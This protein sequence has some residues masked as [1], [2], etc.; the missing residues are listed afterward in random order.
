MKKLL[1]CKKG[2]KN[3]MGILITILFIFILTAAFL[4]IIQ[5]EFGDDDFVSNDV[6]GLITGIPDNVCA[7]TIFDVVCLTTV[8]IAGVSIVLGFFKMFFWTFGDLP[9]L[10]DLMIFVPLRI[11]FVFLLI[12]FIPQVGS[13]G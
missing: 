10:L 6:D 11:I 5:A 12:K 1:R 7:G 3:D 13:G 2:Q 8:A 4:P 9:F